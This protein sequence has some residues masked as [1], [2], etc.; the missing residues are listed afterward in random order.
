M[1]RRQH[2]AD[3]LGYGQ[4]GK[5]RVPVKAIQQKWV[6]QMAVMTNGAVLMHQRINRDSW[7]GW[8]FW[9]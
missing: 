5:R 2:G 4:D 8:V 6:Y 9:F 1:C 3:W 7:S